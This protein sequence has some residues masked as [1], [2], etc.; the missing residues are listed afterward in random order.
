LCPREHD[1]PG[2]NQFFSGIHEAASRGKAREC[3][4]RNDQSNA[5]NLSVPA[6]SRQELIYAPNGRARG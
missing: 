1:S 5:T 3:R 6:R 4:R 2:A